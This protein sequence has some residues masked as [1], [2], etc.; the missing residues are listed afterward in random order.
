M[1]FTSETMADGVVERLFELEVAGELVPGVIWTGSAPDGKQPLVLMGHGGSQHKKFPGLVNRAYRYVSA[2]GFAVAAIDAPGHGD[3]IRTQE[4]SQ[5][6]AE[7]NRRLTE[8]LPVAELVVREMGRVAIQAIPEW[9]AT[10]DALQGLDFIGADGAVGYW[11]LSMGGAIGIPLVANEPRIKAAV[12]GLAGLLPG[13]EALAQ[14]ARR[15]K[16]PIEFVLQWDDELV[17]R[18]ASLA[19]FEAFS[20]QEK[21]LHANPGG[22]GRVS[23]L[24]VESWERF[25][26]RHLR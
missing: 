8:G 20:S 25:F 2:L 12:L 13:S 3:R 14:A 21:T 18:E 26:A 7:L 4:S 1:Q 9:Q 10:L 5:F 11:G 24:E 15:I 17:S 22:H 16:I 6:A 23:Q 19:L